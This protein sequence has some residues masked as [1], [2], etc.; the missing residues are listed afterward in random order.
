MDAWLKVEGRSFL[1]QRHSSKDNNTPA[2]IHSYYCI[3][4]LAGNKAA[5]SFVGCVC[6]CECVC[7]SVCVSVRVCVK[8]GGI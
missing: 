2:T 1:H 5:L 3:I 8:G 4:H 7:V 6:V